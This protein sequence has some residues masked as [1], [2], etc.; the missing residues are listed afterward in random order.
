MSE[1]GK[2]GRD[3]YEILGVERTASQVGKLFNLKLLVFLKNNCG[4]GYTKAIFIICIVTRF[5]L[6][7]KK[8]EKIWY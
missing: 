8:I 3:F 4:L 1:K 7:I 6:L 5:G 2:K